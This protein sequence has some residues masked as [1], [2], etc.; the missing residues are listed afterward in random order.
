[1]RFIKYFLIIFLISCQFEKYEDSE[2]TIIEGECID[3]QSIFSIDGE[4]VTFQCNDYDLL[5]YVSLNE[6]NAERGNDCWGWTDPLTAKEYALMG[7]DNGTAIVDI[8][9]PYNPDYLGKIPTSTVSSSW[10]DVKVFNDHAFIVSEAEN[11]GMQ[12]FDLKKLRNEITSSDFQTDFLYSGYGHSHNIAI[13][14]ETGIAYTLGSGRSRS[15]VGIHALDINSPLSPIL[16]TEYPDF[17]YT[18]DA[19]IVNYDGPDQDH[20]G[21]EIYVGSNQD[22]IVIVDVSN[23]SNPTLIGTY[24]YDHQYTHQAWL[25]EDHRYLLLGDELDEINDSGNLNKTRTIIINLDDL[26]EPKSHFDYIS[27]TAAIDHNGYV[28]GTKYYLASYTS[29]LRVIDLLNID[30]KIVREVGYFDTY[31]DDTQDHGVPASV[32][33]SSDPDDNHDGKKGAG[34]SFFKGAW[35]VY[36]FFQSKNIVISDI[37]RGLFIVRKS[38]N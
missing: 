2:Q 12:V 38:G 9:D 16:L 19:Q 33:R 17:G 27:D 23:K 26:D 20:I 30:Q 29:G 11:H 4:D 6:M 7:L 5:G 15:P 21:K 13:N 34:N 35:S 3:G 1:M 37:N 36:P 10:R 32:V 22:R 31:P 28:V 25:T 18:H 24:F 8:T 14:T